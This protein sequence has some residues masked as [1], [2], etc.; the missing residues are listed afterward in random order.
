MDVNQVNIPP[1]PTASSIVCSGHGQCN[2]N[3]RCYCSPGWFGEDC[4]LSEARSTT[5]SGMTDEGSQSTVPTVDFTTSLNTADNDTPEN[6]ITT[7]FTTKGSS[8]SHTEYVPPNTP[9]VTSRELLTGY[10]T[11]LTR[12][13]ELSRSTEERTTTATQSENRNDRSITRLLTDVDGNERQA[14]T[15]TRTTEQRRTY[16]GTQ[17][18]TTQLRNDDVTSDVTNH[19]MSSKL[20]ESTINRKLLG[21]E[22]DPEQRNV[23]QNNTM[24]VN[25]D[26]IT[27]ATYTTIAGQPNQPSNEHGSTTEYP[28]HRT[29]TKLGS[30][31]IIGAIIGSVFVVAILFGATSIGF[32]MHLRIKNG[33]SKKEIKKT[34]KKEIK[35]SRCNLTKF[36]D[37][38]CIFTASSNI[39]Y[40]LICNKNVVSLPRTITLLLILFFSIPYRRRAKRRRLWMRASRR[41][42]YLVGFGSGP[43][44]LPRHPP[45]H[46]HKQ[47]RKT[48]AISGSEID[49]SV[50]LTADSRTN[51]HSPRCARAHAGLEQQHVTSKVT[52]STDAIT[53]L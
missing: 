3:N 45:N 5:L 17:T 42:R 28:Y 8:E 22:T 30:N 27:T 15:L 51:G 32:N 39:H 53:T 43:M 9:I 47:E 6:V 14:T 50:H 13:T 34:R 38:S 46:R 36:K 12:N 25:T 49:V 41:K 23:T 48:K 26:N 11:S 21:T 2:H 19:V 40:E 4:S 35:G 29:E 18:N 33:H 31:T 37:L 20:Y 24:F 44:Y 10:N 52:Q 16:I 7:E 1:C